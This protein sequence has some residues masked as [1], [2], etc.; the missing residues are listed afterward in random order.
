MQQFRPFNIVL[1][2]PHIIGESQI[3][4]LSLCKGPNNVTLDSTYKNRDSAPY[5]NSLGQLIINFAKI[6]PHGLL[7]FFPSYRALDST[8][9]FWKVNLH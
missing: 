7:I 1:E 5:L 2:N 9:E 4:V 8:T 6:I 3:K